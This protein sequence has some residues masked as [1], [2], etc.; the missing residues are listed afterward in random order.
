[1]FDP[2]ISS[3]VAQFLQGDDIH[4]LRT[5][6]IIPRL[7]TA[8]GWYYL[9]SA[10][11]LQIFD[12]DRNRTIGSQHNI[13]SVFIHLG[14]PDLF[15]VD[16]HANGTIMTRD[17]RSTG[18]KDVALWGDHT[19]KFQVNDAHEDD[20]C[21]VNRAEHWCALWPQLTS[22]S[23]FIQNVNFKGL[24]DY[25]SLPNTIHNL[26]L[27]NVNVEHISPFD[28]QSVLLSVSNSLIIRRGFNHISSFWNLLS[29]VID[30]T[31]K[32]PRLM[33]IDVPNAAVDSAE[34]FA[35][36]NALSNRYGGQRDKRCTLRFPD[37]RETT[38]RGFLANAR[39][40]GI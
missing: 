29:H 32:L 28:T 15:R 18:L 9:R 22:G 34:L 23:L 16:G 7:Y 12:T 14:R 8:S 24:T 30:A 37:V 13:H 38:P 17:P 27:S 26:V 40:P 10:H 31:A 35:I 39:L 21:R 4:L 25:K 1:M 5:Q 3:H 11:D 20:L 33:Y 36:A 6:R 19:Y 2:N